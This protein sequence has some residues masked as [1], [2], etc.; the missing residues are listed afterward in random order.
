MPPLLAEDLGAP[1]GPR[2]WPWG[3]CEAGRTVALFSHAED[4][5]EEFRPYMEDGWKVIDPLPIHARG[6]D[7]AWGLFAVYDGH[8]GRSEVDY[9][10]AKHHEILLGELRLVAPGS[11]PSGALVSAFTKVDNQLA[12]LGAW[13][14]G[15]TATLAL[16]HRHPGG[17][18]LRV[19]NVGDSRAVVVGRGGARRVSV[20]HRACDADEAARVA[21][22]GGVV[23]R[24]RVGGQLSVSRSLGD[25][26]LKS[27]GLSA[28]PDVTSHEAAGD[29]AL[30][31]ASDGLW[32]VMEDEEARSV[33]EEFVDKAVKQGGDPAGVARLL[34]E[35]AARYLVD[36]AK[37]LGSRDNITALVAFL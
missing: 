26:H 25:H 20:D 36:R 31:I 16:V 21:R 27:S 22:E 7:G 17:T 18:T 11:D 5:N 32:D 37:E 13:N 23:R 8:G 12:M 24:G 35:G 3:A 2:Q 9:C 30:I 10:L 14:S 1:A 19:A 15:C 28:V 6:Q 4:A 29:R 34:R 33:L